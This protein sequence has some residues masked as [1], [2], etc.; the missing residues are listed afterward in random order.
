MKTKLFILFAIIASLLFSNC[1]TED[2]GLDANTHSKFSMKKISFEEMKSKPKAV[3]ALNKIRET[4]KTAGAQARL[5]YDS[6]NDF[7]VDTDEIIY[8]EKGGDYH[9]YTFAV[10]R[11]VETPLFE[12]LVMSLQKDGSYSATLVSYNLTEQERADLEKEKLFSL[13]GKLAVKILDPGTYN[14]EYLLG[15][16]NCYN[17][18]VATCSWHGVHIAGPRCKPDGV[19]TIR[20]CYE[21]EEPVFYFDDSAIGD[22]G[23]GGTGDSGGG[24]TGNPNPTPNPDPTPDP[25]PD[26]EE[27]EDEL[28]DAPVTIPLIKTPKTTPCDELKAITDTLKSNKKAEI[29]WLKGKVNDVVEHGV[30]IKKVLNADESFSYVPNRVSSA[31]AFDVAL[32]TGR[33]YVYWMHS[34][35]KDISY[36]MFSFGDVKFIRNAY[37]ETLP[38]RQPEAT[39]IV[40]CQ[41]PNNPAIKNTYALK[42]DNFDTLNMAVD[43]IWN[44]AKYAGK[45]DAQKIDLIHKDQAIKYD[46][47]GP[48]LEFSF[49]T[50]FQNFGISLYKA[51]AD[52]TSWTKLELESNPNFLP[53]FIVTEKPCN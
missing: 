45:T 33:F 13:E 37:Q 2:N 12:N 50:Q 14:P 23:G 27:P 30:E 25:D 49:L 22:A 18:N 4:K 51:N 8:I 44:N 1:Q 6:A 15:R 31:S 36:G 38:D 42:V 3:E 34:H 40:V 9:S 52:L 24:G 17:V 32:A 41:D 47:Y 35:P 26:N 39:V 43:V 48:E 19:A 7:Y 21:Y 16:T 46:Y 29:E 11:D 5:V 53:P 20:V 10:Y 28:G